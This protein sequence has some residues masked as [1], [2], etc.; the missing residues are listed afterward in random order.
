M[1]RAAVSIANAL[2]GIADRLAVL[3]PSHRDPERFHV[4]KSE[5]VHELHKLARAVDG[6]GLVALDTPPIR[7]REAAP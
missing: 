3:A 1:T 4:E 5:L 7:H 2:A 6:C